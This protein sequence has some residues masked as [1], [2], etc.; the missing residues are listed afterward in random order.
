MRLNEAQRRAIVETAKEHFGDDVRVVLFGSR[1]DDQ[2]RGG[3]IDLLIK[4]TEAAE[5]A[6]TRKIPF[7]VALKRRIGDRKVDVVVQS[8]GGPASRVAEVA[9]QEGV[10]LVWQQ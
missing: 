7:L 5:R 1:V 8:D 3:D 6:R 10:E 2:A 4:T 9:E